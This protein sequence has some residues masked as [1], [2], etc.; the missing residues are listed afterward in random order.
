[1]KLKMEA[2]IDQIIARAKPKVAAL[3]RT[4]GIY[5]MQN[6]IAQYKTHLWGITEYQNSVILH[7]SDTTLTKLEYLQDRFF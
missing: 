7:T 2:A 4:R 6:M 3:L 5:D 1:M